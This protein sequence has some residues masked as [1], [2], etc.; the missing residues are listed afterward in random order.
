MKNLISYIP[1]LFVITT[2]VIGVACNSAQTNDDTDRTNSENGSSHPSGSDTSMTD[3]TRSIV[4][5][6]GNDV[7]AAMS[8]TGFISK[9][10]TDNMI[11]I[12]LSKMGRDKAKNEQLKKIATQMV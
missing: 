12:Q 7:S 1:R 4:T 3:T 9:N 11:E 5:G 6:Q 2:V 10:I 8:D